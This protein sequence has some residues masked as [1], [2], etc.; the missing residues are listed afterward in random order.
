MGLIFLLHYFQLLF[1]IICFLPITKQVPIC[2][3]DFSSHSRIFHW[4]GDVTTTG[5]GLLILTDTRHSWPLRIKGF[6][7]TTWVCHR[8]ESKTQPSACETNAQTDCAT[9]AAQQVPKVIHE[10]HV[11]TQKLEKLCTE[12]KI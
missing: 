4:D 11:L 10:L 2:F 7:L 5:E 12:N 9:A 8:W 1:L 6:V 3:C